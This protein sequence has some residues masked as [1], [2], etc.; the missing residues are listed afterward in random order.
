M[1]LYV[2]TI[3]EKDID[4]DSLDQKQVYI[5]TIYTLYIYMHY[6]IHT[7]VISRLYACIHA[8]TPH[9]KPNPNNILKICFPHI[10]YKHNTM[11][12]AYNIICIYMYEYNN[13][14][15]Y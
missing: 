2:W 1:P 5:Y 9:F 10:F 13:D 15:I 4:F 12:F 14:I 6:F 7:L 11:A 3:R 8:T